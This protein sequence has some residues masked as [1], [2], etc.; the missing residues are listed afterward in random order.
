MWNR[1]PGWLIPVLLELLWKM[2]RQK[3]SVG[4]SCFLSLCFCFFPIWH[5]GSDQHYVWFWGSNPK[6]PG[7]KQINLPGRLCRQSSDVDWVSSVAGGGSRPGPGLASGTQIHTLPAWVLIGSS[8]LTILTMSNC[9]L[10]SPWV[11]PKQVR[12]HASQYRRQLEAHPNECEAIDIYWWYPAAIK[13]RLVWRIR[14]EL[15]N[16][17]RNISS[18]RALQLPLK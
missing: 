2:K 3:L 17:L 9:A 6:L 11:S 12:T 14:T 10:K 7:G 13:R 16:S 15:W 4:R 5:T 18:I 8:S 1:S